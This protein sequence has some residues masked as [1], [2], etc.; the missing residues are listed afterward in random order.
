[1]YIVMVINHLIFNYSNITK[2]FEI[3]LPLLLIILIAG[4]F[5]NKILKILYYFFI[6]V[7]TYKSM[8]LNTCKIRN[9]KCKKENLDIHE[10][11]KSA[12][13]K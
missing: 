5:L 11:S 4:F 13:T 1:M 7:R 6:E 10:R 9:N 12:D 3:F 2:S 8:E